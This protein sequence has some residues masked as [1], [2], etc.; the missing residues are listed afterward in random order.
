[1][2][3]DP[4]DGVEKTGFAEALSVTP[5]S[6]WYSMA[7]SCTVGTA[8]SIIVNGRAIVRDFIN[9]LVAGGVASTT[10]SMYFLNPVWPMILGS[11]AGISQVLLQKFI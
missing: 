7:A 2:L 9:S 1:M 5:F 6:V 11:T 3:L 8:F 4:D 10:A